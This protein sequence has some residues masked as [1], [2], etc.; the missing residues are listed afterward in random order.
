MLIY[1]LELILI[2]IFSK[3][4]MAFNH[5]RWVFMIITSLTL[6]SGLRGLSVGLDT[7]N[8]VNI[9]KQI[10]RN[11]PTLIWRHIEPGFIFIC[12]ILLTINHNYN[13]LLFV[14]ALLTNTLIIIRLWELRSISL[15]NWSVICYYISF[16][17]LS[18][19]ISRQF[20]AIAIL[21]YG[22]KYL[23]KKKYFIY[24]LFIIIAFLFHKSALISLVFYAVEIVDW[25][26]LDNKHRMFIIVGCC[27]MPAYIGYIL[28][29]M[30]N[31]MKYFVSIKFN[32]GIMLPFK[33]ILLFL[34]GFRVQY[35][36][37]NKFMSDFEV[38]NDENRY[39]LIQVLEKVKLIKVYYWI[40]L[41]V[42]FI[43]YCF[44]FMDRI[45]IIFYMFECV[46][47]GMIIKYRSDRKWCAMLYAGVLAY[48]LFSVLIG[49][50]QG[51]VPYV[52]C[53]S[54]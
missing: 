40:G 18:M 51:I 28:L 37:R 34:I 38:I 29:N 33:M 19:N 11:D 17:F 26:K 42:T 31:Y 8:Y 21:F 10:D 2:I 43:G 27:S 32:M 44:A 24:G 16:Y 9:F 1:I 30:H 13:F 5:K 25:G 49:N 22:T 12:K 14:F 6:I 35:S 15:F 41:I 53:R 50:G 52:F 3:R 47:I 7:E 45:G 20:C 54:I 36:V 48:C 39:T 4:A 46:F 23:M